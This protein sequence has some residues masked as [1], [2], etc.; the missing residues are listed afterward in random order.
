[1]VSSTHCFFVYQHT[2][3][4]LWDGHTAHTTPLVRVSRDPEILRPSR[5]YPFPGNYSLKLVY[6]QKPL[7][8]QLN[9]CP[10]LSIRVCCIEQNNGPEHS[11]QKLQ[12]SSMQDILIYVIPNSGCLFQ[13][14]SH[15]PL[16]T[17]VSVPHF[18]VT[19]VSIRTMTCLRVRC[20]Q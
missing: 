15:P 3:L 7:S 4:L 14:D 6:I 8:L 18:C 12:L 16:L 17:L 11:D 9:I 19:I 10:G 20:S 5:D 1:M 2:R 13:N